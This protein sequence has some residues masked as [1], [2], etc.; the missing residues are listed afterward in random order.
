MQAYA[1]NCPLCADSGGEV[2]WQDSLCRV[3]RADTTD[4]PG[5]CRVIW[6]A[7]VREM[8]DLSSADRRH[9]MTLVFALEVALRQLYRPLKINLASLGNQVPHVHWH[10]IPRYADDRHFPEPIWGVAQREPIAQRPIVATRALRHA[11][12]AALAE[13][14]AG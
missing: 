8:T 1:E 14:H 13:E 11:L 6:G 3:V 7:H 2:V 12:V 5:F 10:A 4:Y 9:L